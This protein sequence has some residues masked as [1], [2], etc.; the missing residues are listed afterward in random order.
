[1]YVSANSMSTNNKV[2]LSTLVVSNTS[3]SYHRTSKVHNLNGILS[4][5]I[6]EF[7]G[8]RDAVTGL[9]AKSLVK[10]G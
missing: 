10:S 8:G 7:G 9:L 1:M 4:Y 2:Y 3:S 6:T 5:N